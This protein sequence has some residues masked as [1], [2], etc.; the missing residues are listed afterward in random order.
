MPPPRLAAVFLVFA[1]ALAPEPIRRVSHAS[2]VAEVCR[3]LDWR[4]SSGRSVDQA[5]SPLTSDAADSA[6]RLFESTLARPPDILRRYQPETWG[7]GRIVLRQ[8]GGSTN[9]DSTMRVD[10]ALRAGPARVRGTAS[11]H[12]HTCASS[13]GSPGR[14][15]VL[16]FRDSDGDLH[17]LVDWFAFELCLAPD[18]RPGWAT[19]RA[20][21]MYVP[22]THFPSAPPRA[23][24]RAEEFL[25]AQVVPFV[26][27]VRDEYRSERTRRTGARAHR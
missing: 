8:T 18:P 21:A 4:R 17:G 12:V 20:S 5:L 22:G 6:F 7:R 11:V 26:A 2:S 27:A 10:V 23:R 15:V 19:M 1:A 25:G 3:D 9:V 16:D 24:R 14:L 13:C